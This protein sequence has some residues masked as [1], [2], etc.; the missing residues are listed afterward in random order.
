MKMR[1]TGK[2]GKEKTSSSL[3]VT[4]LATVSQENT[5]GY[6]NIEILP[7]RQCG[8]PASQDTALGGGSNAS[9]SLSLFS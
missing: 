4:R 1:G 5:D 3:C 6:V 7:L 9:A 8:G 2:G